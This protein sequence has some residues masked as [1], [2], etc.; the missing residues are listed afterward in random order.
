MELKEIEEPT[1]PGTSEL[2]KNKYFCNIC[3]KSFP[4]RYNVKRHEKNKHGVTEI[5]EP[6]VSEHDFDSFS[7]FEAWKLD[8]EKSTKSFFR[9]YTKDVVNADGS[10]ACYYKC[11]RSGVFVS[12]GKGKRHLK[13]NGN[14]KIDGYCLAKI[15]VVK[16]EDKCRIT[17]TETHVG[18][19]CD[20]GHLFL[21]KEDRY[22]LATKMAS[23]IPFDVILD[24]VRTSMSDEGLE[25]MH[26]L[27]R[28]DLHNIKKSF[29]LSSSAIKDDNDYISVNMWD[30]VYDR[31]IVLNKGKVS[32]KLVELRNRHKKSLACNFTISPSNDGKYVVTSS[33]ERELYVVYENKENCECRLKCDEC[34]KC[35]QTYVC[36]CMD[37]IIRWNM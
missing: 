22:T 2:S 5:E 36:S 31:L 6:S 27:T 3:G 32:R 35:I 7:S 13:I 25:R 14:N 29:H 17:F 21:S 34:K 33:D 1:V 18:H 10:V 15:K 23:N 16:N 12:R 24:C 9:K 20:L 11:H 37:S 28:K 8:I 4:S 30:R 19:S 26:L